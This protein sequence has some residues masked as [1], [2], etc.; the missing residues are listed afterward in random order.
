MTIKRRGS[1]HEISDKYKL[2][3]KYTPFFSRIGCTPLLISR[4]TEIA[5]MPYTCAL[6]QPPGFISLALRKTAFVRTALF[7]QYQ[8]DRH[9]PN[10]IIALLCATITF[11]PF[12]C[13]VER[14]MH[15]RVWVRRVFSSLINWLFF[16]Q[17]NPE[18]KTPIIITY[19]SF[20]FLLSFFPL[21]VLH[22]LL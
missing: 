18:R 5:S 11:T 13:E 1:I 3:Y 19:S 10:S 21:F 20:S 22:P 2:Q 6:F 14:K 4:G 8:I 16:N 9:N 12:D 17:I 15:W 7:P